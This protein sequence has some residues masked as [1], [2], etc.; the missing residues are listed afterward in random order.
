MLEGIKHFVETAT[1]GDLQAAQNLIE[2]ELTRRREAF[3]GS[4]DPQ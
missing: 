3:Y 1:F 4:D 2:A